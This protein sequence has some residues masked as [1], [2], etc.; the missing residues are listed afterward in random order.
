MDQ[1]K[2]TR[3]RVWR[4]LV[5]AHSVILG[6]ME[7]DLRANTGLTLGQYDVLLRLHEAPGNSLRMGDLAQQVLVTTSGVTR[8]ADRL[9]N[10]G[11]V[12]RVRPDAD[13]RVVTVSMTPAGKETLRAASAIHSRGIAEYFADLVEAEELPVLDRFFSRLAAHHTTTT[14]TCDVGGTR[15][16]ITPTTR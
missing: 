14:D 4:N 6:K 15:L 1:D 3:G 12:E 9:V 2:Q 5:V 10:A 13:R 7:A 8:V 11:L 16:P